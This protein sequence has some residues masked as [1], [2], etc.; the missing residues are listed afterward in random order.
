MEQETICATEE[1]RLDKILTDQF[2]SCSRNYIQSLFEKGLITINGQAV[3]K[4]YVPKIGERISVE[5]TDEDPID[6]APDPIPLDILYEDDAIICVNKPSGM[7]VHPAPGHPRKTFVNALLHHCQTLDVEKGDVRPGIVHR[8]DKETSGILVAAKTRS[9]QEKLT[10]AFSNRLVKKEYLAICTGSP[11]TRTIDASIGRH[12]VRRKEM[13]LNETGKEAVTEV[14][15]VQKGELF[16]L[17]SAKPITGRTHQIRVHLKSIGFPIL[18]DKTYGY[19]KLNQKFRIERQLLHAY[20]LSF[21]HPTTNEEIKL[22]APIPEDF[23]VM[24]QKISGASLFLDL[25]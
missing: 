4:R 9:A 16:S 19:I 21:P 23:K 11:G 20:K 5:F 18:G 6:L 25:I 15:T 1:K 22:T 8:L 14:S 10:S 2:P 17:I 12:P 24:T 3:K 7:V 13:A